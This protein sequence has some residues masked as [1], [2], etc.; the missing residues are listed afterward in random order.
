MELKCYHCGKRE[1]VK[2]GRMEE[3]TLKHQSHKVVLQVDAI[4]TTHPSLSNLVSTYESMKMLRKTQFK[5]LLI[6]CVIVKN[7]ELNDLF[8]VFRKC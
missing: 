5:S 8:I 1:H 3:R 7:I 4:N 2:K 6:V